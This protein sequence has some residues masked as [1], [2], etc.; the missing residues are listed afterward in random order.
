[1]AS[2][3]GGGR[4]LSDACAIRTLVPAGDP[5]GLRIVGMSFWT[6]RC[7]HFRRERLPRVA[8]R[9]EL[10]NP[11]VYLLTGPEE[12]ENGLPR[13]R[14]GES[15][16]V[17][18]SLRTHDS[19]KEFP[20]RAILF[21]S[22]GDVLDGGI[23]RWLEH[24]IV[25]RA[26]AQRRY[27]LLNATEPQAPALSEVDKADAKAFLTRISQILPLLGGHALEEVRAVRPRAPTA[28][29]DEDLVLVV[30]AQAEG[31]ERV[32]L[33]EQSW[34]AVRIAPARPG[35][36]RW[37]AAYRTA[38]VS[39]ITHLA[40]VR[41]IVPYGDS[42]EYELVFR[43][44]ARE[45]D[46]PIPLGATPAAAMQGPRYTTLGRLETA[47]S[48]GDLAPPGE[49]RPK[50]P[51]DCRGS[52]RGGPRDARRAGPAAPRASPTRHRRT[53]AESRRRP[54]AAGIGPPVPR[55]S[56]GSPRIAGI[57]GRI[58]AS[59]KMRV[60]PAEQRG[61]QRSVLRPEH[62]REL[63]LENTGQGHD[64]FEHPTTRRGELEQ[65]RAPILGVRAAQHE[66]LRLERRHRPA[67]LHLVHR[68]P[69]DDRR[70][71]E[72]PARAEHRHHPPFGDGEAEPLGVGAREGPTD[73]VG[74][75][76]QPVGQER[77]ESEGPGRG[78]SLREGRL[79]G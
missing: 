57:E 64:L 78:C 52:D 27:E 20:D 18:E 72:R 21:V 30:P 77:I 79:D 75:H 65:G 66:R 33:G 45:L 55:T 10:R 47:G 50:G 53:R 63:G 38:P 7:L 42:G 68:R 59:G 40:P 37:V 15:E 67:H 43:E 8:D 16:C 23:R 69:L 17:G 11:G 58:A 26:R 24:A 74:G 22:D 29:R 14:V 76:R 6:G 3:S 5:D 35:L 49:S 36:V 4:T 71:R 70:R 31:F 62:G 61:E 1:M 73:P 2:P 19:R 60:E 9:V 32:F 41:E 51:A 48:V 25:A 46:R 56:S 54:G 12:T 39:A 34:Y 13:L 28:P 44:P